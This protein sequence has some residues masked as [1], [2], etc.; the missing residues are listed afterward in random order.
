MMD[1]SL[2]RRIAISRDFGLVLNMDG[3]QTFIGHCSDMPQLRSNERIIKVAAAFAGYMGL[4][5]NGHIVTCGPAREFERCHQIESLACIKDIA[6]SEGHTVAIT[7]MGDVLSIDE[8]GGWDG[9]PN[10]SQIVQNWHR[11]K[12]VAVGYT[13]IIGLTEEGRVLYHSEDGFTDC[14]FYDKY[15][16]VVQVD[17]Y[18]HYYGTDSSAILL[19]DGTVVSDTFKDVRKWRNIVHISVGA[20]VIIGLKRDG[21]IEMV[22]DRNKRYQAKEW[23]NLEA[24][25]C[26]FFGV[27]GIT[28]GGEILSI[29]N[30]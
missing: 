4:T 27:I 7:Q 26:K 5:E 22:D 12:Q 13:N 9:I 2:N 1:Y 6:A 14:N 29:F 30:Q 21:T 18:S 8:P 17:C 15:K 25:V 19:A 16:N 20:D 11:I 24:I 3:S 28:R 10:H 23:S